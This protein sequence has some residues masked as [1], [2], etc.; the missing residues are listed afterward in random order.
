V[1]YPQARGFLLFHDIA[2]LGFPRSSEGGLKGDGVH[3]HLSSC[4]VTAPAQPLALQRLNSD[5]PCW[6]FPTPGSVLTCPAQRTPGP[7]GPSE[8]A[9]D[10]S[11]CSSPIFTSGSSTSQI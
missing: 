5:D 2:T 11:T 6:Y 1:T 10:K 3:R 4:T 9:L 8:L 7:R